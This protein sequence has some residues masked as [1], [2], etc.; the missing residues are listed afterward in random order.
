MNIDRAAKPASPSTPSTPHLRH[1][2]ARCRPT[3]PS[4]PA[5]SSPAS[6]AVAAEVDRALADYRFDEA[7][8]AIYQ[9]FWGEL[10]RLV[11][12]TRQAPPQLRPTA[13]TTA[14]PPRSLADARS[15]SSKPPCACSRPF[16]PFLTEEIWH[17]LYA[18]SAAPREVHRPHPLPQPA[19]FP[20]DD[21]AVQRDGRPCRSSS[22]PSARLRKELGVPEKEATPILLYAAPTA[23][24]RR[25][26]RPTPTCSPAWPASAPS[27]SPPQPLTGDNARST[28]SF[29]VAVVYER[30][31]DIPA[32]RERL[33]KDLAKYEKGLAAA[34]QPARQRS[35]HG[36]SSRPHRRRPAQAGRRNTASSTTRPSPPSTA[37]PPNS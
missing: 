7:A 13:P 1:D 31:I 29:D 21:A 16:M 35:L 34:E 12:R 6:P 9:F 18:R 14:K 26:P 27:S 5:G 36:Q 2:L 22:S 10:L 30:Q 3:P 15:A 23:I 32:E 25:S 4:K 20:A 37:L 19:D 33:T 17:A 28:A 11:P 8:N 24:D